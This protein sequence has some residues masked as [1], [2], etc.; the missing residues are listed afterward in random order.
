MGHQTALISG[1]WKLVNN[2]KEEKQWELYNLSK[3]IAEQNDLYWQ[4]PSRALELNSI[5]EQ[6]DNE[7]AEPIF[8]YQ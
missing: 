6:Y 8:R 7:M 3:D 2:Q 5:W 4:N 1:N